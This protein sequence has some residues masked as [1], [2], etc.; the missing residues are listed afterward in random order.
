MGRTS[1]LRLR[2][3]AG[4]LAASACLLAGVGSAQAASAGA[5]AGGP[6]EAITA[7]ESASFT[8]SGTGGS[9]DSAITSATN[10]ALT[11]AQIAGWQRSQCYRWGSDVRQSMGWWTATSTVMCIR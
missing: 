4:A 7:T 8:G 11:H 6:S 5:R 1:T 9:M 10:V 2:V 3:T